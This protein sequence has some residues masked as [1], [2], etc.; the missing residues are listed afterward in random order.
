MIACRLLL[1]LVWLAACGEP[2][3]APTAPSATIL[4]RHD[5][6]PHHGGVVGMAGTTHV[7]ALASPGG[8]VRVW[9]TDAF[10]Q[11]VPL[12]GV[13]G[14]VSADGRATPLVHDGD[15]LRAELGGD[16]R[17]RRVQVTLVR[18]GTALT[19]DF[20][21][22]VVPGARAASGV[23]PDGCVPA[24]DGARC[25]LTFAR[26]VTALA[27]TPAGTTAYVGAVD[28][29]VSR[30]RLPD[31]RLEAGFAAPPPIMLPAGVAHADAIGFVTLDPEGDGVLATIENRLLVWGADGTLRRELPAAKG[32]IRDVAWL[33]GGAI[34]FTV[35]YDNVLHV[36]RA[37]DG[38]TI[39]DVTLDAE[40]A[41]VAVAPDGHRLAVSTEGGAIGLVDPTTPVLLRTLV[42]RG[43]A[44]RALAFAGE[45]LLAAGDDGR[46]D[47]WDVRNGTL[48][49][50]IAVGAPLLR[51]AVAARGAGVAAI[52]GTG[53]VQLVD[54][55]AERTHALPF[56]VRVLAIAWAGDALLTGDMNGQ[57]TH[58]RRP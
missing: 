37:T 55:D 48:T 32:L 58:W 19:L 27:A 49:H 22:P 54:L 34:A 46:V 45:R 2:G 12:A 18:D 28:L 9:V 8:T 17:E 33:R 39:R 41:A 56:D 3:D 52:D 29:G 47:V 57:L 11:P 25:T 1:A 40:G 7:E 14:S 13:A 44:V 21:L 43:R 38:A 35:F 53:T 24:D 51:L 23:P 6:T 26:P 20:V 50:A 31:G 4:F 16:G 10:R 36:V 30:W 5:H 42:S 15:L